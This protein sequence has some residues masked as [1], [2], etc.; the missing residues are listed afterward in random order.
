M[1]ILKYHV[2][3]A[4]VVAANLDDGKQ[5]ATLLSAELPQVREGGGGREGP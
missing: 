4:P 2:L 1:Q 3:P 5:Y